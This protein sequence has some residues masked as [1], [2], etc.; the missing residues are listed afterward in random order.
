MSDV[1]VEATTIWELMERRVAATPDATMFVETSGAT[2][3]FAGLHE[4]ALHVAAALSDRGVGEASVVSWL[5]PTRIDA[6]VLMAALARLGA[7]QNPLIPLYRHREVSFIVGQAG[8]RLLLVPTTWRG[9]DY[10]AMAREVAGEHGADVIAIADGEPLPAADP[11][12]LPPAPRALAPDDQPVRW[13]FYTSGTTAAPKGVRHTDASVIA[14]TTGIVDAY[15]ITA[16]DRQAVAFPVAHVGGVV[17]LIG[18][19]ITGFTQ[20]LVEAFDPPTTIPAMRQFG[21]TLAGSG[22]AFHLAYL[23]AQR[24]DPSTPLFPEVRAFPGGAAPKPATLH[25]TMKREL[26]AG[27]VSSYGL[28][29]APILSCATPDDP[30]D[31]LATTEGRLTR[32]VTAR[33][34]DLEGREVAPGEE[35]ELRVKGP[36]VFR[37]YV[38]DTLDADAFDEEGWFRTGDLGRVDADGF[39]TITGRLKDVIIRKGETISASEVEDLIFQ[40]PGVRDVAVIGVPDPAAGEHVCAIVV[41]AD[42]TAPP[43]LDD[44]TA[45]LRERRLMT[46]KLPEQLELLPE[47]PRNSMGK[48]LKQDLRDRFADA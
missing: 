3:T 34:V 19:L 12:A 18:G 40:H 24:N 16:A 31:K 17:W 8:S 15:R 6:F 48:V 39:V 23:D 7:V 2:V 25:E 26:G 22:T 14:A 45:F 33:V 20:L 11:G 41:P 44:V 37:G 29:E 5:L 27:V 32:G 47:L 35:G 36:Q 13:L 10:E 28:T 43:T 38:D 42:A 9:F 21:I 30:D 46:Q 4:A 1:R